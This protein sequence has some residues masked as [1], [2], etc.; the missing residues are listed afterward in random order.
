MIILSWISLSNFAFSGEYNKKD[1]NKN[2]IV[3]KS[4]PYIPSPILLLLFILLL[5]IFVAYPPE[6]IG[7]F[8]K[9]YIFKV[10]SSNPVYTTGAL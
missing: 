2:Y 5:F 8:L 4:F 6:D 3:T 1:T 7:T 10:P 9:S